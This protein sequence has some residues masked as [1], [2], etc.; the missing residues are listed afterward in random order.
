M[1]IESPDE[2]L[3]AQILEMA[4]AKEVSEMIVWL[5]RY[6]VSRM[7]AVPNVSFAKSLLT[8]SR[9]A[10]V[11]SNLE[12]PFCG[13]LRLLA[14]CYPQHS[15]VP[16]LL[17]SKAIIEKRPQ[18]ERLHSWVLR[19]S[20]E[21]IRLRAEFGHYLLG[22]FAIKNSARVPFS[23]VSGINPAFLGQPEYY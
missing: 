5:S 11:T 7:T 10:A 23:L 20:F 4:G 9:S 18:I 14:F 15:D 17:V 3:P 8:K 6:R 21:L 19:K 12:M 2:N 1:A 22:D 13:G 16:V